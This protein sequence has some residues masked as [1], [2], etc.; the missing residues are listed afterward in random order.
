VSATSQCL[1][2]R[3]PVLVVQGVAPD[4][5]ATLRAEH[6]APGVPLIS[7]SDPLS[8]LALPVSL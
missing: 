5:G 4:R 3:L 1:Q 8:L 6:E 2:E 7:H